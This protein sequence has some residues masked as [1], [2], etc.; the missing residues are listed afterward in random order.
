[1]LE[2]LDLAKLRLVDIDALADGGALAPPAWLAINTSGDTVSTD[3]TIARG[4]P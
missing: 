1:L 4:T 2:T 3:F